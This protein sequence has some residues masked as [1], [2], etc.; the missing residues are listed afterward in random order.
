MGD[1]TV[2]LGAAI[3]ALRQ[4]LQDALTKGEGENVRFELSPIDLTLQVEVSTEATGGLRWRIVEARGSRSRAA[5]QEL[6]VTL[7]PVRY[8]Q[9]RRRDGRFET[10]STSSPGAGFG[11]D[12]PVPS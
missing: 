2:D 11:A 4:Q 1:R 6:K 9:G 5:S 8:D 10:S 7:T 3:E 12:P